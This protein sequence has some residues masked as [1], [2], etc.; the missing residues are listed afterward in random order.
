MS[1]TVHHQPEHSHHL[2]EK[3]RVIGRTAVGLLKGPHTQHESASVKEPTETSLPTDKTIDFPYLQAKY[4][5]ELEGATSSTINQETFLRYR[6]AQDTLIGSIDH[7]HK[8]P[9][10][11]DRTEL[12][13]QAFA[14]SSYF[15]ETNGAAT[16]PLGMNDATLLAESLDMTRELR[17]A[18]SNSKLLHQGLAKAWNILFSDTKDLLTPKEDDEY[19]PNAV[20]HEAFERADQYDSPILKEYT[21]ASHIDAAI[22]RGI[23]L[24]ERGELTDE[25]ARRDVQEHL[26]ELDAKGYGPIDFK[27][28]NTQFNKDLARHHNSHT[29]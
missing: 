12:L 19:N 15:K 3:V 21:T 23:T 9:E 24:V 6:Y 29:K 28:H 11:T 4:G 25:D 1:E 7:A 10:S 22:G 13:R 20:L 26:E 27:A 5:N 18:D 14:L 16:L 2:T 8:D 17:D